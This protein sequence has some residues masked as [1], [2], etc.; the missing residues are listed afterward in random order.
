MGKSSPLGLEEDG[1]AACLDRGLIKVMAPG[2]KGGL[3]KGLEPKKWTIQK[4][5][6]RKGSC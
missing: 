2:K 4:T 3:K 6:E 1:L 5:T